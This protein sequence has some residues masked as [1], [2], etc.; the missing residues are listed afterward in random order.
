[1]Q[2]NLVTS[3]VIGLTLTAV[4]LAEPFDF[5][6]K[7]DHTLGSCGGKLI[8]GDREIRYEATDGKHSH[9]WAF[10]D[11]QKL[12]AFGLRPTLAPAPSNKLKA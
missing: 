10:I 8:A 6:V 1:M 7:H 5:R 3:L 11:I 9:T 2:F 4:C 12:D